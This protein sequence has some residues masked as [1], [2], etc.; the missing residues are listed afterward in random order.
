MDKKFEAHDRPHRVALPDELGCIRDLFPRKI[1]AGYDSSLILAAEDGAEGSL[2]C[3][4]AL[5][6]GRMAVKIDK[7]VPN[8]DA[9]AMIARYET[10]LA[11]LAELT[12][13][14][15]VSESRT[16]CGYNRRGA[17]D[18]P[19]TAI[20]GDSG[21]MVE[22]VSPA[23]ALEIPI[24]LP[25]KVVTALAHAHDA[26]WS[27]GQSFIETFISYDT[28]GSPASFDLQLMHPY[29]IQSVVRDLGIPEAVLASWTGAISDMLGR[30]FGANSYLELVLRIDRPSAHQRLDAMKLLRS[31]LEP[32][33]NKA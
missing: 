24:D 10:I 8:A 23:D 14:E 19:N 22:L 1:A 21:D 9:A 17:Q 20:F 5:S 4:S 2:T 32:G 30:I 26:L 13:F 6:P 29:A 15:P 33:Q 7:V 25:A 11:R 18:A 28:V 16:Y 12:G 3:Y 31:L 27:G